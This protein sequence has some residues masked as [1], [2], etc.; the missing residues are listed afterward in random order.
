MIFLD[1]EAQ[2]WRVD[3]RAFLGQ[4]RKPNFIFFYRKHRGRGVVYKNVTCQNRNEKELQRISLL[5]REEEKYSARDQGLRYF[6]EMSSSLN[7]ISL[8]FDF[9]NPG[10]RNNRSDSQKSMKTE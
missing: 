4:F 2:N 5:L 10:A 8:N 7:R 3:E 9:P 6:S 1:L